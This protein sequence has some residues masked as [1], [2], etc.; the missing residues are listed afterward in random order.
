MKQSIMLVLIF[1][2]L[3]ASAQTA[4]ITRESQWYFQG[5]PCGSTAADCKAAAIAA[6]QANPGTVQQ[7][8][9]PPYDV[10]VP[11]SGGSTGDA[12]CP[13]IGAMQ[14]GDYTDPDGTPHFV[15]P[16]HAQVGKP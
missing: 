1:V 13:N 9:G 8:F 10:S 3:V 4:T 12:P 15:N 6:A 2:S 16:C 7:V 11:A 14:P 5:V